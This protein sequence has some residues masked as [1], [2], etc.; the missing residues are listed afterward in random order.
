M[1]TLDMFEQWLKGQGYSSITPSGNPSTTYDYKKRIKKIC[2]NENLT[3]EELIKKIDTIL[4]QY[5]IG[6]CK[7]NLGRQSN[8]AVISALRQF[9]RFIEDQN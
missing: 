8:N 3:I 7:E 1:I 4:P 6:G 9:K 2:D 5:D